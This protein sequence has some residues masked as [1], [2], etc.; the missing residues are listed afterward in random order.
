[1]FTIQ[2]EQ[3]EM[4][5]RVGAS[6]NRGINRAAW[7]LRYA[8]PN[9]NNGALVTAG[10]YTV[11][12]A[13]LVN[14]SWQDLG[15]SQSF[16]VTRLENTTFP[17]TNQLA[18]DKFR[19][20]VMVLDQAI[21]SSRQVLTNYIDEMENLK[22]QVKNQVDEPAIIEAVES[23]RQ[24]LLDQDIQLRGN[25]LITQNMEL[26][27]PSIAG[28][29]SRIRYSFMGT[30]APSTTTQKE[31]YAIASAEFAEWA[32]EFNAINIEINKLENSLSDSGIVVQSG[33]QQIK[34]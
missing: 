1:M 21:R 26:I 3:G 13:K 22:K 28:R 9:G 33:K 31:S 18:Q 2:D 30:T 8:G 12:M 34:W 15:Q 32:V 20:E 16:K 11:S 29:V 6:A 14:G 4:V 17:V 25:N 5:A 27:P 10:S 7:N 24:K 19:T 23:I